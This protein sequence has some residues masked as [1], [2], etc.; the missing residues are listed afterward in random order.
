[1]LTESD[2]KSIITSD[3]NPKIQY[4]RDICTK[5]KLHVDGEGLQEFLTKINNYENDLQYQARKK[6]AI[7][8]QFLTEEL[9]RPTD[10]VFN[11][12]GGN[13]NYKF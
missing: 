7:T 11:A 13:K 2:V 9:L 3:L 12:K 6:F 1:M 8:N 4:A 10:N 5:L